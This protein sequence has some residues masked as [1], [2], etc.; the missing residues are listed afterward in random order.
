MRPPRADEAA[1]REAAAHQATEGR[2]GRRARGRCTSGRRE[3]GKAAE[4]ESTEREAAAGEFAEGE[5][6][7]T[8]PSSHTPSL[9]L[10]QAW[11]AGG[12]TGACTSRTPVSSS[13]IAATASTSA[14]TRDDPFDGSRPATGAIERDTIHSGPPCARSLLV[15]HHLPGITC[16]SLPK[17]RSSTF[18]HFFGDVLPLFLETITCQY[19]I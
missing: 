2:R 13:I 9:T 1:A 8:K 4:R 16:L 15:S 17:S 14:P 11:E 12:M 3:T 19:F 18:C 10:E 7:S 5:A 6:I